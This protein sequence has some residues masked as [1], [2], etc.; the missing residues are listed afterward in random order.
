MNKI[1]KFHSAL[2][3]SGHIFLAFNF[4]FLQY[5]GIVGYCRKL[6]AMKN[7]HAG[8]N[9]AE[10]SKKPASNTKREKVE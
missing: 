2:Y 10:K 7:V 6:E 5:S 9:P 8:P 4:V 1:H 3:Y